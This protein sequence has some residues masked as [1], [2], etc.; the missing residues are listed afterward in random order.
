MKKNR[1]FYLLQIGL[2][3]FIINACD[4]KSK[5]KVDIALDLAKENKKELLKVVEYYSSPKDSLKLKA[6]EFLISNMIYHYF[7]N[8]GNKYQKAFDK[9]NKQRV[10]YENQSRKINKEKFLKRLERLNLKR[11]IK[12]ENRK[13]LK[14]LRTLRELE[15]EK[16]KLKQAKLNNKEKE[17][18]KSLKEKKRVK[19]ILIEK[20]NMK[21]CNSKGVKT[22]KEY[23]NVIKKENQLKIDKQKKKNEIK[24]KNISYSKEYVDMNML[25]FFSK[26]ID[27]I[28]QINKI[29]SEKVYDL[30]SVDADFLIENIE[31][32]FEA[33]ERNPKKNMYKFKDFLEFV[34]PYRVLNE[35]IEKGKR[36][37]LYDKFKWVYDSIQNK[38]MEDIVNKIYD[39]LELSTITFSKNNKYP[40]E[41]VPSISEIEKTKFGDCEHLATYVVTVLRSLGIPSSID[42]CQRWGNYNKNIAHSWVSYMD[43]NEVKTR[44]IGKKNVDLKNLYKESC[45]TKVFRYCFSKP[46]MDVTNVYH[47]TA[48]IEIDILWNK[49]E[50]MYLGVFNPNTGWD[51]VVEASKIKDNK[52]YFENVGVGL[53]Y[54]VFSNKNRVTNLVNNPFELTKGGN[55]NFF[56]NDNKFLNTGT[57]L[58][59]YPTYHISSTKGINQKRNKSINGC[60][61]QGK[62][63]IDSEYK[64]IYIIKD[65]NTSHNIQIKFDK[66]VN[67]KYYRLVKSDWKKV[68]LASFQLLDIYGRKVNNIEKIALNNIK[69][70]EVNAIIDNNPLT[71]VSETNFEL[72]LNLSQKTKISGFEIQA[73]NDDNHINK[74]ELYE[75]FYWDMK[76]KSLG[77]QNAK[78]TLLQYN[79][80]PR[81]TIYWLKNKTKGS[82]EYVF[83]FNE[84]GEQVWVGLN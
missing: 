22:I 79:N 17:Y 63:K 54:V 12:I 15:T 48:D 20:R 33:F 29:K 1:L 59:K 60:V 81:N 28:N 24:L 64:D 83:K 77:S 84:K 78:D 4:N 57:I 67:Y 71:F 2:T 53:I 32:S 18:W 76:W 3:V 16:K 23:W 82:E 47:N 58:R 74:N 56:N 75:L 66:P 40:Y 61:L 11:N 65:L 49:G 69:G 50:K 13:K 5:N 26:K 44:D 25:N 19:K 70:K 9:T 8:Y 46:N 27:S 73:R 37:E 39:Q 10:V 45:I 72:I 55:V 7:D 34:L 42:Y 43:G 6:A 62:S 35:P 36:R 21:L 38:P 68:E 41:G 51:K 80:I 14:R 52:V 30:Y 31:L